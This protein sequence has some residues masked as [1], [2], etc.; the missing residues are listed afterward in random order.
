MAATAAILPYVAARAIDAMRRN[1]AQPPTGDRLPDLLPSAAPPKPAAVPER[2]Y[3]AE[4]LRSMRAR[5]KIALAVAGV[6]AVMSIAL[7][8]WAHEASPGA[9]IGAHGLIDL[10]DTLQATMAAFAI[11]GLIAGFYGVVEWAHHRCLGQ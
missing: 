10:V 9:S 7:A 4:D 3:S 8:I 6:A 2:I 11:I 1:E 5:A